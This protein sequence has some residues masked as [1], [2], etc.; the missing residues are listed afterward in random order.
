MEN[1]PLSSI[2][3]KHCSSVGFKKKKEKEQ[4]TIDGTFKVFQNYSV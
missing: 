4:L 1:D 2:K 3:I